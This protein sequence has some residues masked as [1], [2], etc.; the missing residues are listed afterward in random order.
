MLDYNL[1]GY[2]F[3]NINNF[4]AE[5]DLLCVFVSYSYYYWPAYT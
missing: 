3:H 1:H 4:I 5:C 2:E